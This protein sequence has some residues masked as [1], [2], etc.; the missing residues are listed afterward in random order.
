MRIAMSGYFGTELQQRLQRRADE[1]CATIANTPGL[2]SAGRMVATDDVDR[3][4][5]DYCAGMVETE[6]AFGFRLVAA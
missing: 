1:L 5:L 6:G 2:C 3:V 4:G